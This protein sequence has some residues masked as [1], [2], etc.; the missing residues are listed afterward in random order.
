MPEDERS[1]MCCVV[2]VPEV[3]KETFL[4]L[5]RLG[6]LR[7]WLLAVPPSGSINVQLSNVAPL[8][9]VPRSISP[10]RWNVFVMIVPIVLP[11]NFSPPLKPTHWVPYIFAAVRF[12]L[13]K[14]ALRVMLV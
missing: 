2:G 4:M 12:A 7:P 1:N 14:S 11:S 6:S 5:W 9:T 10:E 3:I 8:P 13:V